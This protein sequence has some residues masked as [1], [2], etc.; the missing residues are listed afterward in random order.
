[1]NGSLNENS[2][3]KISRAFEWEKVLEA[4]LSVGIVVVLAAI[5]CVNIFHF[6]YSLNADLA[7][8]ALLARLIWESGEWIPS[9]WFVAA[10]TRIIDMP[11]LA[12]LF[13]GLTG[14]ITVAAGLA[15]TV[16][17]VAI[18]ASCY[19]FACQC[20]MSKVHRLAFL[21]LCFILPNHF[22]I[23]ELFFLWASY[24]AIH[25]VYTFLA[26]GTYVR[27]LKKNDVSRFDFGMMTIILVLSFALGMQGMRGI[28]VLGGPLVAVEAV[29]ILERIIHKSEKG[30]HSVIISIWVLLQVA[31][32]LLGSMFEFSVGQSISR[33]IRKGI[34]KFF[35]SVLPD[36]G[37]C[38]GFER[39][40]ALAKVVLGLGIVLLVAELF[41]LLWKILK[42]AQ[43]TAEDWAILFMIASPCMTAVFAAFTTVE[44]S[45]R[46]YFILLFAIPFVLLKWAAKLIKKCPWISGVTA[47]LTILVLIHNFQTIY[48]PILKSNDPQGDP[49]YEV[50]SFLEENQYD[51]AYASFESA[52]TMTVLSGGAVQVSPVAS[53]E[54]MDICKWMSS[55]EWYVPNVPFEKKTAY[56][57]TEA[58]SGDF[59]KFLADHSG[60]VYFAKQIDKYLIYFSDYNFSRI[61]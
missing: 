25:V 34:P 10:E 45:E 53:V 55:T 44:S 51:T 50:V 37:K 56:I 41:W 27:L 38:L 26:L 9:T 1:M 12:A 35:E 30:K 60:D 19:Y 52:N 17:S 48:M 33:N 14:N 21:L 57:V 13:Y 2:V 23:L 46:Y 15:C 18:A 40:G 54:K 47:C 58:E 42:K 36:I 61:D 31:V 39:A 11:N 6:C 49:R 5:G 43:I 3:Q 32:G 20:S 16:L 22:T 7:S 59:E 29:R 8:D 4:I 28:L 24:Y